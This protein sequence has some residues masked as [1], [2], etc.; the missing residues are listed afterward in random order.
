[1]T[2]KMINRYIKGFV[3]SRQNWIDVLIQNPSSTQA[4]EMILAINHKIELLRTFWNWSDESEEMV[5]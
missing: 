4:P 1:M 3:E 2:N 5:Y